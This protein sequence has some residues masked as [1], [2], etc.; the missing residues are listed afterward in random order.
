MAIGEIKG[1]EIYRTDV[2]V[3]REGDVPE[4]VEYAPRQEIEE[5]SKA[6]RKRLAFV[7]NNTAVEFRTMVT[8]T[9][10]A[11]FPTTG[12]E[13]K[14]HLK[15]FLQ[16]VRRDWHNPSYLW[17]LE[18]Q[19][20]GAPHVHVLF[21]YPLPTR[22]SVLRCVRLRVSRVWYNI[23]GSG[24]IRH[25]HAGTRCE[26][27]RK[28]DGARRYAVKYASK[29]RQKRVPEAFRDVGRF[30]GCS[31]DV[32]PQAEAFIRATEDDIRGTLE[33]WKYAP[34]DHRPIYHTLYNQAS[35]FRAHANRATSRVSQE[36][37]GSEGQT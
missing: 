26:K 17:F 6:S 13:V 23:V 27:V 34:A 18:F 31:R 3:I 1:V 4:C 28:E 12:T 22:P 21:D 14:R 10:P 7:A 16:A 29:M 9:Y 35:R 2:V 19:K 30:W 11:A 36:L 25:L 33:E 20:R 37:E 8:L 32:P 24:D 5:F 15:A